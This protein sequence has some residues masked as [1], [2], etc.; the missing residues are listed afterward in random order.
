VNQ[1]K[2]VSIF[3]FIDISGHLVTVHDETA[4][5]DPEVF[6]C[7]IFHFGFKSRSAKRFA[8]GVATATNV[9]YDF[10]FN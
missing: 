5:A 4:F 9:D 1:L 6:I 10:I 7:A 3:T 2:A 8:L